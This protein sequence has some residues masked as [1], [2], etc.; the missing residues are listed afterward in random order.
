MRFGYHV[1][2]RGGFLQAIKEA[3]LFGCETMQVFPSS[4]QQWGTPELPEEEA[5]GFVRRKDDA[6]I[7]P[8]VIHS[9]YLVNMASPSDP[10][11]KRSVSSLV[12]SLDR[13]E[14]LGATSVVTHIG[15]H[16]EDSAEKGLNRIAGAVT[17]CL[18]RSGDD[19][20]LL[21][22]T[23]AGAGTSIGGDF[24]QFARIFEETGGPDRLGICLDTCHIF[25]AGYD[26]RN[27][28]GIDD[29]L[30]R[31]DRSIGLE[32]LK[33]L[34]LNDSKGDLGSHMDRHEHIGEG[35]IGLDAFRCIVN[36]DRLKGLPAIV[37]LPH[38]EDLPD[39]IGILRSLV[40][41]KASNFGVRPE[42]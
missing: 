42:K 40:T 9:I 41:D 37:E 17:E 23:T 24:E 16:K 12:T 30:G 19:S 11:Y 33:L 32:R 20:L 29:T 26:I 27:P 34:H 21:L 4:P 7:D 28:E 14:R 6:G 39:D 3:R 35:K 36:H 15:N 22:E 1:S 18:E 5:R 8:V 2:T 31:L 25:A 13:A 38:G 10:V